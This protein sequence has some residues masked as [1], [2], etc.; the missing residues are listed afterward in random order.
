M[1][2]T[3]DILADFDAE[4]SRTRQVLERVPDDKLDWQA[5][6]SFN[7][8]GWN[9]NHLVEIVGWVAG[10]LS[11]PSWDIAPV[12]GEPYQSPKLATSAEIL[13]LFDQ[14]VDAGR[15]AIRAATDE[16][17]QQQWSLLA[18]GAPLFTLPRAAVLRNYVLNHLIHHRAHLCVYLR[19]NGVEVPGMYDP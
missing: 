17:L 19:L 10:T 9:A 4:M 12:D 5:H 15:G 8:I 6:P 14:N 3:P 1:S 13:A 2:D 11:L 7:T 18:G 16:D